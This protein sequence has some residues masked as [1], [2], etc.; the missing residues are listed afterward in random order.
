MPGSDARYTNSKILCGFWAI[1]V[2]NCG[3][4]CSMYQLQDAMRVLGHRRQELPEA[5]PFHLAGLAAAVP[6]VER[7]VEIGHHLEVCPLFVGGMPPA[8]PGAGLWA[9]AERAVS[10]GRGGLPEIKFD[11]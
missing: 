2:R 11:I 10:G 9:T 1:D 6:G 3:Q 7:A 5:G 4:Q 8:V